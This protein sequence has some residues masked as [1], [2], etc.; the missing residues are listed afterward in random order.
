M[1]RSM[2][3]LVAVAVALMSLAGAGYALVT[4]TATTISSDNVIAYS[5]NTVDIVELEATEQG[6]VWVPITHSLT[7][8][9]PQVDIVDNVM[10]VSRST[11]TVSGYSVKVQSMDED[12]KVRCWVL[13]DDS[14]SWV[15]IESMSLSID[16]HDVSFM[17]NGRTSVPSE[18]ITLSTSETDGDIREG[19]HAFTFSITYARVSISLDEGEDTSFENLSGARLVFCA[20]DVDPLATIVTPT[21]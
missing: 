2:T 1:N 14:R 18:T 9:G 21:P 19:I 16:G 7:I 11:T 4:Y 12:L 13:L 5:G 10:S 15:I 17:S 6:S 20:S 3:M 8:V